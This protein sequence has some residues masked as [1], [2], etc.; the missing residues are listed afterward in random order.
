MKR[1]KEETEIVGESVLEKSTE[2]ATT[3]DTEKEPKKMELTS[4]DEK[5]SEDVLEEK[6]EES[7]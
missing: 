7:N 2:L 1:D 5:T 6:Q 3:S 4:E